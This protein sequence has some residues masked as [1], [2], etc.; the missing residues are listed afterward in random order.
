MSHFK[1]SGQAHFKAK[2]GQTRVVSF[3]ILLYT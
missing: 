3:G 1:F 2:K